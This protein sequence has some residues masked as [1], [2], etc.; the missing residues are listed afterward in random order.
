MI[1]GLLLAGVA[2]RPEASGPGIPVDWG[3]CE[4]AI[5][6][7]KKRREQSNVRSLDSE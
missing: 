7:V 6:Q 1:T 4:Q 3:H 5:G 2:P